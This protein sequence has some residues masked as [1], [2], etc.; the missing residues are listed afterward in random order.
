M[1]RRRGQDFFFLMKGGRNQGNGKVKKKCGTI[2]LKR[3]GGI[4]FFGLG[5]GGRRTQ[6][7]GRR[8]QGPKDPRTQEP[9]NGYNRKGE[10]GMDFDRWI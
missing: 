7:A 9:K 5:G 10:D 8:T 6:D 4:G 2:Q 1:T 3:T